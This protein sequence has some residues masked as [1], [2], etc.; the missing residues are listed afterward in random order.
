MLAFAEEAVEWCITRQKAK[1]DAALHAIDALKSTSTAAAPSNSTPA[2]AESHSD[3]EPATGS[4]SASAQEKSKT[5]AQGRKI[6][7]LETQAQGES[8]KLERI[9][10]A[11]VK[12]AALKADASSGERGETLCAF[13]L[14]FELSNY[15][16]HMSS[17]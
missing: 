1:H 3:A 14:H 12:L 8:F 13:L 10:T 2:A 7:E 4:S 11:R 15:L 17:M 5:A 6:A 16:V 9:H